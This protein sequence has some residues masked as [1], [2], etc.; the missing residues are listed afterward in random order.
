MNT[1]LRSIF[2]YFL[3]KI[4]LTSSVII[5]TQ[6]VIDNPG[7]MY[8]VGIFS[9]CSN[10]S[11]DKLNKKAL[12]HH[13][14]LRDIVYKFLTKT[15]RQKTKI[16]TMSYDVCN[17]KT[18]LI[19]TVTDILLG[20]RHN[21][22][23]RC[24]NTTTCLKY[25]S[26]IISIISYVD[27]TLTRLTAELL[28]STRIIYFAH[29]LSHVNFP[30]TITDFPYF[31]PT[32]EYYTDVYGFLNFFLH[33]KWKDI[34]LLTILGNEEQSYKNV[35]DK[36]WNVLIK[37]IQNVCVRMKTFTNE[38]VLQDMTDTI[39]K[40]K[41][42][43]EKPIIFIQGTIEGSLAFMK[44]AKL[45]KFYNYTVFMPADISRYA[46]QIDQNL[47]HGLFLT[48]DQLSV[49]SLISLLAN[50]VD[51]TFNDDPWLIKYMNNERINSYQTFANDQ[52][53]SVSY[54]LLQAVLVSLLAATNNIPKQTVI[55]EV[56]IITNKLLT[57]FTQN[58]IIYNL[59]IS[60]LMYISTENVMN[61]A[62][63]SWKHF[64]S[65][66][67]QWPGNTTIPPKTQCQKPHC[68]P[69]FTLVIDYIKNSDW[70]REYAWFCKPCQSGFY[71]NISG[72]NNC[73]KCDNYTIPNLQQTTCYDPYKDS[74][75]DLSNNV[76]RVCLCIVIIGNLFNMTMIFFFLRHRK[77]PI[78]LSS[79]LPKSLFQ[80][81]T[82]SIFLSTLWLLFVGP[83]TVI[84]C[85]LRP[86]VTGFLMTLVLSITFIKT[87]KLVS[88]FQARCKIS[89][90]DRLIG[91]STEIFIM[92]SL[93]S[94]QAI[95][96]FIS[97]TQVPPKII[98]DRNNSTLSR[99]TYC[100]T[101]NHLK[102]QIIFLI[103][104]S[105]VCIIQGLRARQ[106]P[107][108]FKETKF[109]TFAMFTSNLMLI[110]IFPLDQNQTIEHKTA[111]H[112][113]MLLLSNVFLICVLYGC[114]LYI[115]LLRPDLNNREVFQATILRNIQKNRKRSE[116]NPSSN[117]T[118]TTT[119]HF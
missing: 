56:K 94:I 116:N 3:L 72:P 28:Q 48:S 108:N 110:L 8:I 51:R 65:N 37:R 118:T 54:E 50:T 69:G 88:T 24:S 7:N 52:N 35:V 38:N 30:D 58:S 33:F 99:L 43:S 60:G 98:C 70:D 73:Q 62:I 117:I 4:T 10:T 18:L 41:N 106:L 115:L 29:T 2:M 84:T 71:K 96:A 40:L 14:V 103:F 27:P 12:L 92:L 23:T 67:L 59:N 32:N 95:I 6:G 86:V 113:L 20:E 93:L 91:L 57:Y 77:T 74:F 81:A 100:N 21:K 25:G 42:R 63:V 61:K 66:S 17:N 90:S 111:I 64:I 5:E 13:L 83:P 79:N 76:V 87:Q 104:I 47:L 39:I 16:G 75:L 109:I 82:S 101:D 36:L 19:E 31:F 22:Q 26:N 53:I 46:R 112:L 49:S 9:V 78:A 89:Q 105:T 80:L 34:F 15:M 45:Y 55:G 85:L 1:V 114:K 44:V 102:V 11:P 68:L 119:T 107:E 97:L